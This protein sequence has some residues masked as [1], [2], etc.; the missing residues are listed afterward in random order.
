[1]CNL[2]KRNQTTS[3]ILTITICTSYEAKEFVGDV[4]IYVANASL[5][6]AKYGETIE[7]LFE[8]FLTE[9]AFVSQNIVLIVDLFFPFFCCC[10]SSLNTY[11]ICIQNKTKRIVLFCFVLIFPLYTRTACRMCVFLCFDSLCF[12]V[13]PTS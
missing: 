4:C 3:S 6:R 12:V 10:C 8:T 2:V 1:M 7:T 11:F 5:F 13:V 9:F